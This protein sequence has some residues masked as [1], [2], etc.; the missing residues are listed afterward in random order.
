[1]ILLLPVAAIAAIT[2]IIAQG[3]PEWALVGTSPAGVALE[4]AAALALA[5]AGAAVIARGPDPLSGRLLMLTAALWLTAEWENPGAPSL[6]FTLGLA[7]GAAAPATAA[8][9]LLV[10]GAGALQ[11]T[12]AR[13]AVATAYAGQLLVAGFAAALVADPRASGCG[14]CPANLLGVANA[15][16]AA[17]AFARWGL[18]LGAAALAA[19]ALLAVWRLWRASA[20][21]RRAVAPVL[22]PGIAFLGLLVAQ[23]VHEPGAAFYDLDRA[24]RLT[25]SG[26]LLGVAAGVAWQRLAVRRVRG[27]LASLVGELADTQGRGLRDLLSTA[28]GDPT[29]ELLYPLE[30]QW[31]DENGEPRPLPPSGERDTTSLL[32]GGEVGALVV[33]RRGLLDDASIVDALGSGPRLA[34]DHERLQAQQRAQLR[35]LRASRTAIVAAGD[36]ERRRLERHLHDGAQQALAGLA[37]AIGLRRATGSSADEQLGRA[38]DCVRA[39]LDSVRTLAHA[40]YPP[41]LDE[42][43]LAPALDVL[44]EW[45]PHLE[46]GAVPSERLDPALESGVYFIVAALAPPAAGAAVRAEVREADGRLLVEVHPY[47]A[48]ADL[49]EVEDRAGALGGRLTVEATVGGGTVARVEIPCAS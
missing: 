29:L 9:A 30:G 47:I 15:P 23:H 20:A 19:A 44:S 10:H 12:P 21:G 6:V 16:A 18:R 27:R 5:M 11:T 38:Q 46:L 32:Q 13:L 4:V 26:A 45:R 49:T 39:A 31:I 8:H 35:R 42:A 1:V 17:D 33:H 36:A 25:Q 34:I 3:D 2:T 22:I 48:A 14:S 40:T 28:L 24:L 37:M 41:V 43:G 7:T